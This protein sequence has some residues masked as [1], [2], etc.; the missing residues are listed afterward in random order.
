MTYIRW[1]EEVGAGDVG[2]GG[3]KAANLGEM[4]AAGLPAPG[5]GAGEAG[6][7]RRAGGRALLG[8]RRRPAHCFLRRPA[9]HL[10]QR[11]RQWR[12]TGVRQALL[13]LAVDRTGYDVSCQ[14]GC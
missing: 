12:I 7:A 5:R 13:G 10:S 8:H 14:A 4:V 9:R 11:L 3:G 2:L 1:F 6:R